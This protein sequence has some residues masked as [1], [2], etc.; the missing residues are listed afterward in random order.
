[1]TT[2]FLVFA[3]WAD[4]DDRMTRVI[5]IYD[6]REEAEHH[7]A[8]AN[9]ENDRVVRLCE[10]YKDD[11]AVACR[12]WYHNQYDPPDEEGNRFYRAGTLYDVSEMPVLSFMKRD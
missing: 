7:A 4:Y 10:R 3:D 8:L 2:V 1:M 6:N 5:A 9:M 12:P 11:L